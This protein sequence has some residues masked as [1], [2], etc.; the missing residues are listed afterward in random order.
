VQGRLFSMPV[1][2]EEVASLLTAF[3]GR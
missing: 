2:A 3:P 1:P